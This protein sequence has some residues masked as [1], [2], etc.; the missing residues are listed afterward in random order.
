M[1]KRMSKKYDCRFSLRMN[2]KDYVQAEAVRILNTKGHCISEFVARAVV[3][4]AG[5]NALE[6]H[7]KVVRNPATECEIKI[8]KSSAEGR[9]TV[10]ENNGR[11]QDSMHAMLDG[12]GDFNHV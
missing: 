5:V 12:L 1:S 8:D 4:Y 2:Q 7:A 10:P 11:S 9:Q 3:A 6:S